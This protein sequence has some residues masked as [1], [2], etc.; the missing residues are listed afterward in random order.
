VG[1]SKDSRFTGRQKTKDRRRSLVGRR[2]TDG[3]RETVVQGSEEIVV[4]PLKILDQQK[5]VFIEECEKHL[6]PKEYELLRLFAENEGK[7]ISTEELALNLW[8]GTQ[9]GCADEVKQYVYLLRKKIEADPG[10]PQ[11]IRTVKG[12][13]YVLLVDNNHVDDN[14]RAAN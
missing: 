14:H 12:F 11:L 4:G 6:S 2:W 7:V 8:H 13:G 5:R 1:T 10:K 9:H 3:L